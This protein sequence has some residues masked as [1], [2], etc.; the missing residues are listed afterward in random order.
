M[1]LQQ[2]LARRND[3][4]TFIVHLTR[5][6][7]PMSSQERLRKILEDGKLE[8]G[9]PLGQAVSRIGAGVNAR[10]SQRVVC[11][12]ETPLEYLYLLCETIAGRQ[13]QLEPYGLA[14]TKRLARGRGVNPVWYVDITP[15]HSWLT[16]PL[17]NLI[18]NATASGAYEASN[19][20]RLTPFI[21]QMG[22]IPFGTRKEFWWEREWRHVGDFSLPSH[23]I[24]LCPEA[25]I[26]DFVNY[27]TSIG[28]ASF[29]AWID[30]RWS[31]EEMIARLAG[32][33][34]DQVGLP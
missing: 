21:E 24:G 18:D 19:V 12:T 34:A 30:P 26:D 22:T 6:Q 20:A 28:K 25:E 2:A 14:F 17:N 10:E 13:V 8:A 7:G 5:S 33:Q 4:S 29:K 11:F 23:V 16:N 3:L 27:C 1:D 15:G 31:L 9:R 32:F